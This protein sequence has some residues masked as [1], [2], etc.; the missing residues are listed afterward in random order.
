[1]K[2]INAHYYYLLYLLFLFYACN[3]GPKPCNPLDPNCPSNSFVPPE[4]GINEIGTVD[5]SKV[6]IFW[7]PAEGNISTLEY[8]FKLDNIDGVFSNWSINTSKTYTALEDGVDYTFHLRSRYASQADFEEPPTEDIS[9]TFSVNYNR[10]ETI[11]NVTEV[12]SS[13]DVTITWATV[14]EKSGTQY[15]YDI[16]NKN[17]WSEWSTNQST[18]LE[19]LDEGIHSFQVSARYNVRNAELTPA[20]KEFEVN[21]IDGPSFRVYPLKQEVSQGQSF[22]IG[23]IAEEVEDIR[24]FECVIEYD[25]QYISYSSNQ[26]GDVFQNELFFVDDGTPGTII[27][28]AGETNSDGYSGTGI[29]ITLSFSAEAL[30]STTGTAITITTESTY[31]DVEGNA[32][33]VNQ[34]KEG[35][36][37][38]Q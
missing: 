18:T 37:V 13:S 1:M 26:Q 22:D 36:V 21:A 3:D 19:Y 20:N 38:I 14:I 30:T 32:I 35:L 25:S 34:R 33:E 4:A 2:L 10:P 5:D 29:I 23:I 11:I 6:T 27:I 12:V 31:F 17:E 24:Y 28:S 9:Q 15:R 8:Q 7:Q 16:N